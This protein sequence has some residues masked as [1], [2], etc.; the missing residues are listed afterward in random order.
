MLKILAAL[1]GVVLTL[2]GVGAILCGIYIG[3]GYLLSSSSGPRLVGVS[4]PSFSLPAAL[5]CG[6]G[7]IVALYFGTQLGRF[8]RGDFD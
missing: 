5:A 8:A 3:A 1:V 7:G 2:G 6:L 4:Q